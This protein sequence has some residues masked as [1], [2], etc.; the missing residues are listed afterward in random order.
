MKTIS[1]IRTLVGI[2]IS[3][4]CI[5][6]AFADAGFKMPEYETIKL[7]NGITVFLMEHHEVP[8]ININVVFMAGSVNDDKEY[9]L[10]SLY[11]CF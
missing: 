4:L 2:I 8:L 1:S 3:G 9:G 10:A 6:T 11:R 5:N 7:D